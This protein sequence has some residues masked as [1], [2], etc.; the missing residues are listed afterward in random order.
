[1]DD[2]S[3]PKNKTTNDKNEKPSDIKDND[4][5]KKP[6]PEPFDPIKFEAR[7]KEL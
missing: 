2:P 1:L 4:K 5:T 3:Q 6:P 7:I